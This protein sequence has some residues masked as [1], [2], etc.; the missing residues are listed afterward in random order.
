MFRHHPTLLFLAAMAAAALAPAA[1]AAGQPPRDNGV[2]CAHTEN[3]YCRSTSEV[4][5][6]TTQGVR[7]DRQ[8]SHV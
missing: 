2:A 7:P 5:P 8:R 1:S 3:T 4:G 6:D